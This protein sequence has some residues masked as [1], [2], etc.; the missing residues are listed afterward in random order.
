MYDAHG[1]FT[2]GTSWLDK[3]FGYEPGHIYIPAFVLSDFLAQARGS[4][5]DVIRHEYA[6]ALAHYYPE[7]IVDSTEFKQAFGG[8]YLS[9]KSFK[10]E[11][12]ACFVSNQ[13]VLI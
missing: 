5:R 13:S 3:M 2:H 10:M 12:E 9:E 1:F 7:L 8:S 11:D 6:H 4:L